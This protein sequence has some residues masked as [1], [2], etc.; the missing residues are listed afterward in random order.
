[1]E[2]SESRME[3]VDTINLF[4]IMCGYV[5][6]KSTFDEYGGYYILYT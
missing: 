6:K 2:A 5:F 4:Y 1:M 3:G